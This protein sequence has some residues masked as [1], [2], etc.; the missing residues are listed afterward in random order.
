MRPIRRLWT[1]SVA[2][3]LAATASPAAAGWAIGNVTYLKAFSTGPRS[4]AVVVVSNYQ[5]TPPA[6]AANQAN[7]PFGLYIDTPAGR[8]QFAM[9]L[10]AWQAGTRVGIAGGPGCGVLPD[11]EDVGHVDVAT[12]CCGR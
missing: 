9:L 4:A 3:I 5:G 6:C 10:S 2:A 12:G 11:S 8:G 7:H 1:L